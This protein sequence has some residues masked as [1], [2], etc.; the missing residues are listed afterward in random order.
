MA[1]VT[2]RVGRSSQ[3]DIVIDHESVS[4]KHLEVTLTDNQRIFLVDCNSSRGTF[5]KADSGWQ[6][7]VQGYVSKAAELK[8]GVYR[9]RVS[10]LI[11]T[12]PGKQSQ[13]PQSQG[14]PS[15]AISIKPKRSVS[16]GEVINRDQ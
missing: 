6:P 7:F 3:A 15:V 4:R 13:R 9:T 11:K 14:Q 2:Y 1:F 12:L 5:V 8:L 10:D 16:T